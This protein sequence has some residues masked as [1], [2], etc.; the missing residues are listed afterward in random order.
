MSDSGPA[1]SSTSNKFVNLKI[2][3][4]PAQIFANFFHATVGEDDVKLFRY[5]VQY[6][7]GR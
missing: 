3:T 1:G 4:T 2:F 5:H 6:P 7:A